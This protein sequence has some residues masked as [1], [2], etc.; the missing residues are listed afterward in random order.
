M[1]VDKCWKVLFEYC[2][3]NL[4]KGVESLEEFYQR[5]FDWLP[6]EIR[7]DIGHFNM[8]HLAPFREGQATSIPYRRRDFYKIMLVKGNSRVHFGDRVV[9]VKSRLWRSVILKFLINGNTSIRCMMVF[10]V[11]LMLSFSISSA[12]VTGFSIKRSTPLLTQ[13]IAS[14]VL[15]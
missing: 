13:S 8:F 6:V 7:K 11:F 4:M 14:E 10:T 5:K 12:L 15:A 9:E 1:I 2:K 3:L